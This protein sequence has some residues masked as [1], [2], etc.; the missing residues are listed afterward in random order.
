MADYIEGDETVFEKFPLEQ[1]SKKEG[2]MA[3]K[4]NGFWQC[5]DTIREL[6]LLEKAIIENKYAESFNIL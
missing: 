2:L 6:E 1:I 3:Y 4:H 5:A